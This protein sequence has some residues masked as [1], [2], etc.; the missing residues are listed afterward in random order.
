M[1]RENHTRQGEIEREGGREEENRQ[2]QAIA[3]ERKR[4]NREREQKRQEVATERRKERTR[5]EREENR[6][7]LV[8]SVASPAPETEAAG[9]LS[10]VTTG[11]GGV[12]AGAVAAV[13]GNTSSLVLGPQKTVLGEWTIYFVP[14]VCCVLKKGIPL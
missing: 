5:Q 6:M 9:H 13:P 8:A 11:S 7:L 4:D 3:T 14:C 2:D 12:G 10:H 1:E